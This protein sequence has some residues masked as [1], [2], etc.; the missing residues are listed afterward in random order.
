MLTYGKMLAQRTVFC[1]T[2]RRGRSAK[3]EPLLRIFQMIS[4]KKSALFNQPC[5]KGNVVP[6]PAYAEP[7]E[8]KGL[9]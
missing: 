9:L 5:F 7:V 6:E 1:S 3:H 8:A 4:G 2:K